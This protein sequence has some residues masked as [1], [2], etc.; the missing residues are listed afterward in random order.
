MGMEHKKMVGTYM[1]DPSDNQPVSAKNGNGVGSASFERGV[2]DLPSH[3]TDSTP[4][5]GYE[6]PPNFQDMRSQ[7]PA[8]G[9]I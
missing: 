6:A 4:K 7:D 5:N 3:G 9:K 2:A 1:G 8:K